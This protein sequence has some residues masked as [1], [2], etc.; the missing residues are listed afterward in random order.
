MKIRLEKEPLNIIAFWDTRAGHIK[1]TRGI[2]SS[3]GSNTP[4]NIE[5]I[6]IN[7]YSL[8]KTITN[9]LHF[10]SPISMFFHHTKKSEID[11]IIGTGTHTHI[12][13]LLKK[14]KKGGKVITCMTPEWPIGKGMDLCFIPEHDS[15]KDNKN[16][17]LTFGP[18]NTAKNNN[19]HKQDHGLIVIGGEDKK[20]HRWDNNKV[21][22]QIKKIVLKDADIKW[23]ISTSPRTPDNLLPILANTLNEIPR[24]SIIPF[25]E[26]GKGWIEKMYAQSR[27]TWVTEDSVSMVYEALSAGCSVG[28][29]SIDWKKKR[30]KIV[31]GIES[32]VKQKK[33]LTF[34]MWEG[35]NNWPTNSELNEANRCAKEILKRWWPDRLQ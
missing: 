21:I 13:M 32:L 25:N 2:I 5:N 29:L 9:W 30:N 31:Q 27:Y 33:I 6:T 14:R 28:V 3:L 1:Q 15:P 24:I 26:T 35:E 12:P 18:P 16:I 11:L 8:F 10:F 4:V 23:T 34:K 20:T 17:F 19:Q 7:N 22:A